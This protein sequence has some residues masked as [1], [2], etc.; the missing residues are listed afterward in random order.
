MWVKSP[1]LKLAIAMA[2]KAEL[3]RILRSRHAKSIGTNENDQ[4]TH[5]VWLAKRVRKSALK[6]DPAP[7]GKG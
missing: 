7:I 2:L 6:G 1:R 3:L 5:L 4:L